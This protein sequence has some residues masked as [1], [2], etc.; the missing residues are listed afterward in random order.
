MTRLM[1]FLT[2]FM[3]GFVVAQDEIYTGY[4]SNKALD[5]YDTVAYFT[6]NKP[7]EGK[8][9]FVTTYKGADWY[10]VSQQHLDMFVAEPEKYAPQYGGYCAWAISAKND[11]ASAD[12]K[13]WAVVD[14]K[15][16]LNYNDDIK[17][18]WDQNRALHIKQADENWPAL[19]R[20]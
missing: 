19:I 4:F 7:V 20:P 3:S 16:Y 9:D 8:P 12:P 1:V 15:L 2:L 14:G 18:K 13:D 10:F 17:R 5:G 11:F 6:D